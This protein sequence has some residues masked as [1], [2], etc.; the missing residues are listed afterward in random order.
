[1]STLQ[2]AE[3][4]GLEGAEQPTRTICKRNKRRLLHAK[5]IACGSP[6]TSLTLVILSPGS[7]TFSAAPLLPHWRFQASA[8]PPGSTPSMRR[9]RARP[10]WEVVRPSSVLSAKRRVKP[11]TKA[12]TS[13]ELDVQVPPEVSDPLEE[14]AVDGVSGAGLLMPNTSAS[15]T[16]APSAGTGLGGCGESCC[17]SRKAGGGINGVGGETSSVA[18]SQ[19][20]SMAP[21]PAGGPVAQ[22]AAG[23]GVRFGAKKGGN[24]A[25]LAPWVACCEAAGAGLRSSAGGAGEGQPAPRGPQGFE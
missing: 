18:A 11:K 1:M 19:S 24:D 4:R 17:C 14:R 22:S 8:A 16:L 15:E 21:G 10:L 23:G 13:S 3:S 5:S 6:E 12:S 25:A 2:G 9:S 7:S 20:S